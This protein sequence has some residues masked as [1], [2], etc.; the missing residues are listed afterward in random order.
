M[1]HNEKLLTLIQDSEPLLPGSLALIKESQYMPI[2]KVTGNGTNLFEED[3][4]SYKGKNEW[5]WSSG[6]LASEPIMPL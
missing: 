2:T 5:L 4:T 1:P 6:Q 3:N